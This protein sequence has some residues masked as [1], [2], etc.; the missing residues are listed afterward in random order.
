[1]PPS[2]FDLIEKYF[3][4]TI[5]TRNDVALGIGDDAAV[6]RFPPGME[7]TLSTDTMIAG[8]HFPEDTDPA[9]IGYKALAVNLSDMAA[10]GAEPAWATLALTIPE[11]DEQWLDRFAAGF[12]EL[13][14]EFSVQLIGGDLTRGPL[15]M[16]VQVHGMV[17]AGMALTRRGAR[18]FDQ[19]YVTGTLGDAGLAL[20]SLKHA[21]GVRG[22][23]DRFLQ[24][25]LNR[26]TPRVREGIAL[27]GLAT[28]AIDI[29]DGLLADLG[30]IVSASGVGARLCIADIPL[31][32]VVL[33]NSDRDAAR[34]MAL[35]AGDDYELCFTVPRDRQALLKAAFNHFACGVTCVGTIL[36]A[37][38]V[39][40]YG[41]DGTEFHPDAIGY[42]HFQ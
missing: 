12:F 40:C 22:W 2:E 41:S 39:R 11:P 28:S 35:S 5:V 19:I 34:R 37:P 30:H 18:V 4:R 33:E 23:C 10:M 36:E 20:A 6:I 26:P 21:N 17:P 25:R 29:S 15:V 31:S 32:S 42:R 8:V 1:M 9:D 27:R 3:H 14:A 24:G 38:G 7:L 16:T 13:A